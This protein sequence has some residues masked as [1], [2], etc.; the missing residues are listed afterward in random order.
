[1]LKRIPVGKLYCTRYVL[2]ADF[3]TFGFKI[4]WT[5]LPSSVGDG[6]GIVALLL[7]I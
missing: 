7:K 2:Y 5:F 6:G 3:S 1:M 4:S